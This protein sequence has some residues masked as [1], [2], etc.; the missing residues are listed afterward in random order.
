[1]TV[2]APRRRIDV[3]LPESVPV[4]EL[5]PAVLRNAGEGLADEGQDHGGWVLRRSDGTLVDSARS[6]AAQELRD[7]EVLHLLPRQAEWPELDYDDVVDAIATDARAQSR[8]WGSAAT[9]RA[10]VAGST[11]ALLVA[12]GLLL[13]TGPSW[14]LPG[15]LLLGVGLLAVA[16]GVVVS[17]VAADADAGTALSVVGTAGA[18]AGGVVVGLGDLPLD[19]VSPAQVLSGS[20]ALVVA[21]VLALVGVAGRTQYAVGG[22]VVGLSGLL[23][24]LVAR[25]DA[26]DAVD[27]AA[28]T[29]AVVVAVT[30]LV[31]LLSIRLGGL[32]VPTLPSTTEDLLA[33][34]PPVSRARVLA[35]VRRSDELL[36]GM[37]GGGALTSVLAAV[38]LVG[39]GRTSAL[40]LVA[41]VAVAGLLRARLFPALRHR[42]PLLAGGAGGLLLLAVAAAVGLEPGTR[43]AVVLPVL[44]VAAAVVLVSG[45]VYRDRTP[46]PYVGRLADVLDVLVVLAVIPTV[47]VVV[48]LY[49]YV[50]GLYG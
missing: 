38:L 50:R 25:T 8:T 13:T 15:L 14:T 1:M 42:L 18:A 16:G 34:P 28:I 20:V 6:L 5:L 29:T 3:A 24:A 31:P 35:R 49:G 23:G 22:V 12:V 11:A 36:T 26:V 47:C 44:V 17:R 30:P 2:A 37:L 46:G 7:G 21:S 4:A 45:L 40:V 41:L 19:A 39:S 9:R 10:G 33:D 43:I 32:P 48:G 27:A